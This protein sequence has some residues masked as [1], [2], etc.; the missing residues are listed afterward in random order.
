[1]STSAKS[2]A[3]LRGKQLVELRVHRLGDRADLA[4]FDEQIGA[5]VRCAD[6]PLLYADY[7]HASPVLPSVARLWSQAMRRANGRIHRTAMLVDPAN[8]LFNLQLQRMVQCTHNPMRQ[9]FTDRDDLVAWLA[10]GCSAQERGML[11]D[12]VYDPVEA[13][14]EDLRVRASAPPRPVANGSRKG[15]SGR[16]TG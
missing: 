12:L 16:N 2:M 1:M 6:V 5:A 11:R 9:I 3:R 14:L 13:R 10:A 7:R 15:E 8:V 4:S